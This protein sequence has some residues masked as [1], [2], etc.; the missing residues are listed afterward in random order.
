M[1]KKSEEREE[2]KEK[3]KNNVVTAGFYVKSLFLTQRLNHDYNHQQ[4]WYQ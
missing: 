2:R 3:Q 1:R 4:I